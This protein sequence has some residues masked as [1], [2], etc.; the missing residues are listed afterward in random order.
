[1]DISKNTDIEV[2]ELSL[3][4]YI[5]F[6]A[7]HIFQI[8]AVSILIAAILKYIGIDV[9]IESFHLLLNY[10]VTNFLLLGLAI[11]VTSI[12]IYIIIILVEVIFSA[13]DRIK[14]V[15]TGDL[16]CV[17][18]KKSRIGAYVTRDWIS[19]DEFKEYITNEEEDE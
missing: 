10:E 12:I 1:M 15:I 8:L 18:N 5:V 11:G 6:L 9:F 2:H 16:V 14:D 7:M 13:Y 17:Y 4:E 3:S 19:S